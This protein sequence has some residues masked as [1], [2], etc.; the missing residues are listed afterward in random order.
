MRLINI[1]HSFS[2]VSEHVTLSIGVATSIPGDD[3]TRFDLIKC[4]D[5]ALYAAKQNGRNQI[6]ESGMKVQNR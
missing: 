1:P 5:E 6:K 2:Q 4:A 3:T